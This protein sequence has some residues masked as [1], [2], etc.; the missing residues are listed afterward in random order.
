MT[1]F[2]GNPINAAH[3]LGHVLDLDHARSSPCPVAALN[4]RSCTRS[5]NGSRFDFMG[6]TREL[7]APHKDKLGWL[8]MGGVSQLLEVSQSG[9][10]EIAPLNVVPKPGETT[11]HALRIITGSTT[12]PPS[13]QKY[14][15]VEFRQVTPGKNPQGVLMEHSATEIAGYPGYPGVLAAGPNHILTYD[16]SYFF[17]PGSQLEFPHGAGAVTIKVKSVTSDR[18]V[19]HVT[20]T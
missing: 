9:T 11:P 4:N 7:N 18:A 13:H 2:V 1:A 6:G 12:V 5:G 8:H 10:Y 14:I 3:E 16:G 19:L 17:K 15:Y 20:V